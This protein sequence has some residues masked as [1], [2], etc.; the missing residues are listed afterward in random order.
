MGKIAKKLLKHLIL[1]ALFPLLLLFPLTLVKAET[2]NIIVNP[3]DKIDTGN[4]DFSPTELKETTNWGILGTSSP[5]WDAN[6]YTLMLNNQ[7]KDK[8]GYGVF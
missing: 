7:G 5:W 4:H 8:V 1:R 6:G 3:G 2:N